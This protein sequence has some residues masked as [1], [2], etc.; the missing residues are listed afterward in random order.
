MKTSLQDCVAQLS[1]SNQ[2]EREWL[3]EEIKQLQIIIAC[4]INKNGG[5][6]RIHKS[7]I[8]HYQLPCIKP[9]F[10]SRVDER[11]RSIVLFRDE[12]CVG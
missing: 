9:L 10:K 11:N 3:H 7:S 2:Q 1:L 5:P 8:E 12:E 6:I 4:L